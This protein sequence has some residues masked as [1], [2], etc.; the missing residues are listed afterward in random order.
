MF[1]NG[2]ICGYLL[3]AYTLHTFMYSGRF[4]L[5]LKALWVHAYA[6]SNN[7]AGRNRLRRYRLY[8]FHTIYTNARMRGF[9][10][11]YGDFG[12]FHTLIP[13]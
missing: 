9:S 2:Q 5:Y 3:W 11:I 13:G 8:A 7:K 12:I 4:P 6:P 10:F 1:P